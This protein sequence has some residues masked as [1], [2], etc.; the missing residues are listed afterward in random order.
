M[1]FDKL[2]LILLAVF[3]LIFGIFGVTNLQ[4][5]WGPQIMAFAALVLGAVCL[6]RAFR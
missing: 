5:T 4:V 6:I 3:M 2:I 1:N